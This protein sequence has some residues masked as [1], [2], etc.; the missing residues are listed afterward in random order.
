[1]NLPKPCEKCAPDG[2]WVGD[3]AM[4][5][6]TCERGRTLAALD[7][8]RKQPALTRVEPR[9]SVEA[10][11]SGVSILSALRYFPAEDGARIV[12]GNELR[13]MCN[14]GDEMLWLCARM[15]RLFT[16]WP[17]VPSMRAV[18]CAKFFPLDRDTR[19]ICSDFPDGIPAEVEQAPER[20]A[21]SAGSLDA[22][23]DAGIRD[24][25]R[26]KDMNKL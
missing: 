26:M 18:F 2:L 1:M 25:A 13:S 10:A 16:E 24:L 6:C 14:N 23:L 5:R 4:R 19:G 15:V 8:V 11:S 3:L 22:Q 21:L 17:G 7:E 12:I 20:K 9:I